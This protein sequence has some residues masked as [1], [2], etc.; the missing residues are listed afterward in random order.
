M[1]VTPEGAAA[2]SQSSAATDLALAALADF[3]SLD[4]DDT[5][6]L[7]VQTADE[8]ALLMME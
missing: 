1:A 2:Q 5:D 3:D 4:D 6:P 7:A 8:L